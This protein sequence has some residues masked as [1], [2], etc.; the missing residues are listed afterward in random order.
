MAVQIFC[1]EL[2]IKSLIELSGRVQP[3]ECREVGL[4]ES[5]FFNKQ[6]GL[7]HQNAPQT[8]RLPIFINN[9]KTNPRAVLIDCCVAAINGKRCNGL[10]VRRQTD[11]A[12][13]HRIIAQH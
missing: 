10:T 4:R 2:K 7:R 11:Q 9:N 5:F 3:L 6:H 12:I 8:L 1:N 13:A